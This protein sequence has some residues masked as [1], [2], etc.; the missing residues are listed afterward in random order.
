[1]KQ[2]GHTT[3]I[4]P[5]KYEKPLLSQPFALQNF[6]HVCVTRL[7]FHKISSAFKS[8]IS[9]PYQFFMLLKLMSRA[10]HI[11]LR[12]PGNLTLLAGIAQLFF[13]LKAKT[14]KYAGNWDPQALQPISYR[15]QKWLLSNEFLTRNM[16]VL[17]YGEWPHQ[18]KNIKPFFT[19]TYSATEKGAYHKTLKT[20]LQFLFV[21]TLSENKNPQLLI[22]LV[23]SL[24]QQGIPAHAH[25]Y[26]DGPMMEELSQFNSKMGGSS[27]EFRIQSSELGSHNDEEKA[28]IPAASSDSREGAIEDSIE[29]SSEAV[30]QRLDD[31]SS[32]AAT[33]LS[34]SP[35]E[36]SSDSNDSGSTSGTNSTQDPDKPSS[37]AVPKRLDSSTST[38]SSNSFTFHGNQPSTAVKKAYEN[39]HFIFLASKSEGWPKTIAEGMW[40]GCV[41]IATP[42]SCVPWM[43]NRS[44]ASRPGNPRGILFHSVEETIK[45]I[46][47]L[48]AAPE[49]FEQMSK[50]AQNWSQQYTMED[51]ERAIK[52]LLR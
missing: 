52:E 34:R 42:V 12:A 36:N 16:K 28:Q 31:V 38:S 3:I 50:D 33:E 21:G 35:V 48:I 32:S 30:L 47:K 41:P 25:F 4:S 24:N 8:V 22:Q 14:A 2:V 23:Q 15:L 11:H 40:H 19:A 6:K 37:E 1:M 18:S 5:N 27:D 44:E 29:P 39:A 13:P 43:L 49:G 17:V 46:K 7:E 26:G 45:N 9:I 10:D 20:P 51:F